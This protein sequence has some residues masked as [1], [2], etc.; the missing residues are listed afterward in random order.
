[1]VVRDWVWNEF[2]RG[3]E[4]AWRQP[5]C[6]QLND[7]NLVYKPGTC[8]LH[9]Q[10]TGPISISQEDGKD[11]FLH[12]LWQIRNVL[13]LLN[14][15]SCWFRQYGWRLNFLSN[16]RWRR[17]CRWKPRESPDGNEARFWHRYGIGFLTVRDLSTRC[18]ALR[19]ARACVIKHT[20]VTEL[21]GK[22]F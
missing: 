22:H 9:R 2:I 6:W 17:S 15:S 10:Y 20:L 13:L 5:G 4:T 18:A 3:I 8:N 21:P 7:S 1:M 11:F 16:S 14:L 12:L 19:A